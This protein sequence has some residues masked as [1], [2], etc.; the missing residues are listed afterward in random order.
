[1]IIEG[2]IKDFIPGNDFKHISES[3]YVNGIYFE[4]SPGT[5]NF[6]YRKNSSNGGVLKGNGQYVRLGY[7]TDSVGVNIIVLIQIP[8]TNTT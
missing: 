1:M 3:F 8:T 6:G 4:Y 5:A 2:T 7:V